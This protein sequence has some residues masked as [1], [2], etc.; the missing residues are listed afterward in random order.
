MIVALSA[1]SLDSLYAVKIARAVS[2]G[3]F[4]VSFCV[5]CLRKIHRR[6][7]GFLGSFKALRN[8]R[9]RKDSRLPVLCCSAEKED[10]PS[11][12][13]SRVFRCPFRSMSLYGR[14][15]LARLESW[16]CT[17]VG[18]IRPTR[19]SLPMATRNRQGSE[20]RLAGQF[21]VAANQPNKARMNNPS[22]VVCQFFLVLASVFVN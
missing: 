19:R 22:S 17:I 1:S 21:P 6:M 7:L 14:L 20:F 5:S 9:I 12:S 16:R 10:A 11:V 13:A 3:W 4:M 18:H 15:P 8:R 2:S